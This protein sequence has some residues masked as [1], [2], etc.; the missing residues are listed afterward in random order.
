MGVLASFTDRGCLCIGWDSPMVLMHTWLQSILTNYRSVLQLKIAHKPEFNVLSFCKIVCL[1]Y[2]ASVLL[3]LQGSL[4]ALLRKLF[5]F[6]ILKWPF[7]SFIGY[8]KAPLRETVVAVAPCQSLSI[9]NCPLTALN[10]S[11]LS[12]LYFGSRCSSYCHNML[13]THWCVCLS[14]WWLARSS[15]TGSDS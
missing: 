11:S 1:I 12:S 9:C 8:I 2:K 6:H 14:T 13:K 7:S 10:S 4:V 3:Q 15:G 5:D